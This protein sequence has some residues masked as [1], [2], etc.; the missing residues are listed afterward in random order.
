MKK[1]RITNISKPNSQRVYYDHNSIIIYENPTGG[2]FEEAVSNHIKNTT[3]CGVLASFGS[4]SWNSGR[5]KNTIIGTCMILF[6][7]DYMV[8]GLNFSEDFQGY[9]VC[10]SKEYLNTLLLDFSSTDIQEK[11]IMGPIV[12][13]AT[14]DDLKIYRQ[15]LSLLADNLYLEKESSRSVITQHLTK[16]LVYKILGSMESYREEYTRN[17]KER[18]TKEFLKLVRTYGHLY[19]DLDFYA[20]KLCITS[21]YLSSAVTKSSGRNSHKWLEE[22]TMNRARY[23]LKNSTSTMGQISDTL[24][25]PTP[26]DFTRFFRQREGITPLKYRNSV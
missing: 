11:L 19:R 9:L 2:P 4:L 17:Q 21:K 12:H 22:A 1:Q 3:I 13:N 14:N 20:E 8:K 18:I 26:A 7:S 15:Y 24:N 25:F 16:A 5:N 6:E 10:I 23:L